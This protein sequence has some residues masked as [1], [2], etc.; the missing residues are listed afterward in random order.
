MNTRRGFLKELG[1]G[2]AALASPRTLFGLALPPR[3]PNLVLIL[4][5][6]LGW[7]D[8]GFGGSEYYETPN[9]DRLAA[10][11]MVFTNAYANAPNCAPARASLLSGQYTPR[12]GVYTVGSPERGRPQDRKLIP[13]PNKTV[14]DP[15][16]VTIAEALRLGGYVSA[17][18]GKWHLGDDP[19]AGPRAQGFAV[20]IAGDR[21]GR[22]ASGYFSPYH[23]PN[24]KDGPPGEYLTDRLTDEALG[25]IKTNR[26]RTFFLYLS[27]FAVHTPIEAKQALISKYR[28]KKGSQGQEHPTYAAMVESTDQSVGRILGGLDQ[29]GLAR[30]TVVIFFSDNGGYGMVTSMVPLRGAKGMVYE[31]GIRVPMIV[32]WPGRVQP[33]SMCHTPVIGTDLYPTMLEMAGVPGPAGQVLDGESLIPLL[34]EK[35]CLAREAIFWHFPGY[36]Q[37]YDR[38]KGPFRA[39]PCSVIRQGDW[40]LIE[41]F[42]DGRLELYNLKDDI[43]ETR[44]LSAARPEDATRLH[45]RLVAWRKSVN[46][47]VPTE[48]NPAYAPS[49]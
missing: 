44:D 16:V 21:L 31:G 24:L 9:I 48:K 4:I 6:D 14:L 15:G 17:S 29:L 22:P 12:H 19:Q 42:E 35:G 36:L 1:L 46:A 25:F 32:R 10:G 40:K 37:S 27:H 28:T 18:I 20:N 3:R 7:R 30:N 5:D 49:R 23:L 41:F 11:G 47:P 8:V 2:A 38:S 13:T 43:G 45:Q 26:D 33:G 39:T 34:S